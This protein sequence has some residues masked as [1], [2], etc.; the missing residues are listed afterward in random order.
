M[1]KAFSRSRADYGDDF[2]AHV[3]EQYKIFVDTEERLIERR[4]QENRFFLSISALIVT[5]LSVLLRQGISDRQASVGLILLAGA[6]LALCFA[7][8]SII[9]SYRDLNTAKFAVINDFEAQLP[10]RMFGSEWEAVRERDYK[11]FTAVEKR[12][13]FIFGCLHGIGVICR[14]SR[15]DRSTQLVVGA[16]WL[17]L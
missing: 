16:L 17:P 2:Q 1:A 15:A 3:L 4:Q 12:V 9:S 14:I 7:W 11:A 6:G 13:P 10:A 5:A 8:H